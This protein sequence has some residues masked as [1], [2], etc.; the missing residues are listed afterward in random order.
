MCH[1]CKTQQDN[2]DGAQMGEESSSLLGSE[3]EE[4]VGQ[5]KVTIEQISK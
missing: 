3:S 2:D 5:E 1:A 4:E